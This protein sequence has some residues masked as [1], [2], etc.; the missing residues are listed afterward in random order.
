[1]GIGRMKKDNS[2][3]KLNKDQFFLWVVGVADGFAKQIDPHVKMS[4]EEWIKLMDDFARFKD[5]NN[6]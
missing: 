2:K 6:D 4:L 1:M 3:T 5:N